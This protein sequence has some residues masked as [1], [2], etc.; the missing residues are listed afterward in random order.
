MDKSFGFCWGNQDDAGLSLHQGWFAERLTNKAQNMGH[1]SGVSKSLSDGM[2]STGF[3][4]SL[5]L[6]VHLEI[7]LCDAKQKKAVNV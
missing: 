7:N 1:A 6:M 4:V 5:S 3:L 2:N